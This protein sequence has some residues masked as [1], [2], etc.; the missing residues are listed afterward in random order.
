MPLGKIA[1]SLTGVAGAA[2]AAAGAGAWA[3]AAPEAK[4]L[5]IISS[6]IFFITWIG[7]RMGKIAWVKLSNSGAASGSFAALRVPRGGKFSGLLKLYLPLACTRR[8]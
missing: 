3:W 8:Q 6:N 4:A 2:A 1:S 5:A 7:M